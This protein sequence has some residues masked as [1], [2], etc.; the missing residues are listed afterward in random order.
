LSL[1]SFLLIQFPK[2]AKPA[3]SPTSSHK[4]GDTA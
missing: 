1:E 4:G 3:P 2:T